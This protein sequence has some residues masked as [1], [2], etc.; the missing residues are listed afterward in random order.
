MEKILMGMVG[1][2]SSPPKGREG[3]N[4]LREGL[5]AHKGI[6]EQR[7]P[8]FHFYVSWCRLGG[9][10]ELRQVHDHKWNMHIYIPSSRCHMEQAGAGRASLLVSGAEGQKA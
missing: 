2:K 7:E 3:W 10:M 1:R 6:S 5:Y 9:I 8:K 4:P